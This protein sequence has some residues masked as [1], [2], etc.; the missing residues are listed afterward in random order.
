MQCLRRLRGAVEKFSPD[1]LQVTL[2]LGG[3][4]AQ[5]M[6]NYL[7]KVFKL[8]SRHSVSNDV[9]DIKLL[10][11][12]FKIIELHKSKVR[13]SRLLDYSRDSG[14][15]KFVISFVVGLICAVHMGHPSWVSNNDRNPR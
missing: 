8:H 9:N 1:R 13:A 3:H 14:C 6:I 2:T 10:R 5:G 11:N 7:D 15:V 12:V 4:K